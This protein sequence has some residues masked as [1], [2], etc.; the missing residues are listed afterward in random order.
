MTLV[1]NR[2]LPLSGNR[3]L[4]IVTIGLLLAA[5][6]PKVRP[7]ATPV[8]PADTVAAVKKPVEV[9]PKPQP[10]KA[11]ATVI[12]LLLPFYLDELNLSHGAGRE[13]ISKADLAMQYYQGFKL[14]LDSVTA[15]GASF[16]LQ[17]FDT[18]DATAQAHNLALNTKI[19]TGNIVVGP[20]YPEEIKSFTQAS[21]FTLSNPG[22]KRMM[23]SP[24]S[25]ASPADYRNPNLV[26]MVPPLEYHSW[27]VAQ[28]IQTKIKPKKVFLLKSGYTE[29]NKYIIP[30]KKAIDSLSKKRIKV[31]ELTVVRG[32]LSALVAQLSATE[33]N[34]FIIPSTDRQFLLVTL[35]SLDLLVKQHKPVTLFGHPGWEDADYLKPELLQRLHTFISSS[36]RVNYKA[37]QVI[38]FIK[39]YRKAYHAEPGEYAIKG[40]DEGLYIGNLA[41]GLSKTRY[42]SN[43]N[44]LTFNFMQASAIMRSQDFAGIHNTFH[45][46]HVDGQGY[47]NTSVKLYQ[48]TNFEL[49]PVE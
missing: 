42:Q 21:G 33:Q 28:Y 41:A 35:R 22:L 39:E 43:S 29:D 24:L 2:L 34:V 48:Y 4:L 16:K 13:A 38:K 1:Q 19:R 11:P 23:V 49:K 12:S 14:A 17:V 3:G 26:T 40:F 36:D 8:K 47:I 32:N 27:K 30:F 25:P 18:K 5:C 6:S 45:F 7:V 46:V 20:V 44:D 37:P 10:A 9:K 15:T 31:V